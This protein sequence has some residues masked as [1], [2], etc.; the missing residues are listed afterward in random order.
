MNAKKR[1]TYRSGAKPKKVD[2]PLKE[3]KSVK[4]KASSRLNKESE[5]KRMKIYYKTHKTQIAASK[6]N[7]YQTHK[8]EIAASRK[9]YYQIH[10]VEIAA[11]EKNYYQSHKAE[12]AALKREYY[13]KNHDRILASAKKRST[14]LLT[15][16]KYRI[17]HANVTTKK[18]LQQ[19]EKYIK[20]AM[21][22]LCIPSVTECR[23]EAE[24]IVKQCIYT[25]N[26]NILT[27]KQSLKNLQRKIE[28]ILTKFNCIVRQNTHDLDIISAF[29]GP[30]LHTPTTET[31]FS[32]AIYDFKNGLSN[33]KS[34]EQHTI[35]LNEDGQA[36]LPIFCLLLMTNG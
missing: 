19:E 29:C 10:K 5:C 16:R 35:I 24:H 26:E 22:A 17:I 30:S 14:A 21:Q 36:S 12:I 27:A 3:S 25:R 13:L 23:L 15:K 18:L 1:S 8:A 31:Y 34:F 4:R 9:N 33:K 7:Y 2:L 11:S 32:E 20:N 6:S 28:I